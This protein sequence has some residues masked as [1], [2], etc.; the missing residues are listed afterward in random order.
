MQSRPT[1]FSLRSLTLAAAMVAFYTIL[2]SVD[3]GGYNPYA[4]SYR[5][6]IGLYASRLDSLAL[7]TS[8]NKKMFLRHLANVEIPLYVTQHI[9]LTDTVLLPPWEYAAQY[10]E[11]DPTWTD[12]R[13]FTYMAGFQPIVAYNDSL[14][15]KNANTF[16]VL[17][18]ASI[19]LA[20]KGDGTNIDS[21]LNEY[22]RLAATNTNNVKSL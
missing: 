7:I 2:V 4:E 21:L 10:M 18:G 15:W 14:R 13:V 12:P 20:R 3:V 6:R 11:T 9:R 1:F 19:W 5:S 22:R 16:I 17:E 8:W